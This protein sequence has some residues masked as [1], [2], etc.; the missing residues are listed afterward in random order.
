[1]EL[2]TAA[3]W[4]SVE[5]TEDY[6]G[7]FILGGDGRTVAATYME[8]S[9]RVTKE[10]VANAALILASPAM[11]KRLRQIAR[12][13]NFRQEDGAMDLGQ[14]LIDIERGA[15]AAIALYESHIAGWSPTDEEDADD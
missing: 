9:C 7:H 12:D 8:D 5:S 2:H 14:R 11:L 10:D 1:M 13:A 4:N 6:Q 3:P 15:K